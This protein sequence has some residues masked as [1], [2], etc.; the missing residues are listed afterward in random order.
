MPQ[1]KDCQSHLDWKATER[2]GWLLSV[3]GIVRAPPIPREPP[4]R[5]VWSRSQRGRNGFKKIACVIRVTNPVSCLARFAWSGKSDC[6]SSVP[7][8][9]TDRRRVNHRAVADHRTRKPARHKA[10]PSPSRAVHAVLKESTSSSLGLFCDRVL[11]TPSIERR[12]AG[13][14]GKRDGEHRRAACCRIVRP[15]HCS[16]GHKQGHHQRRSARLMPPLPPV[17]VRKAQLLPR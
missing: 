3:I 13:D 11:S 7:V 6:S 2:S 8:P 10:S 14:V 17:T 1:P 5:C 9:A 12:S 15:S 4:V 16:T